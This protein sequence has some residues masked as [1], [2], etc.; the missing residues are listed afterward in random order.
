[1]EKVKRRMI[2]LI[3]RKKISTLDIRTEL[4]IVKDEKMFVA[5]SKIEPKTLSFFF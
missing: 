3:F 4:F 5:L 1:M 2:F